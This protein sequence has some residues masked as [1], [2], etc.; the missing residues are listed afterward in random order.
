V[1]FTDEGGTIT[2]KTWVESDSTQDATT[3]VEPPNTCILRC[4]I[5]DTGI[6]IS[7][8]RQSLLFSSFEQGE[9]SMSRKYGGTGLGLAISKNIVSMMD[10]EIWI[11]SEEGVGSTFSFYV[12]VE[13]SERIESDGDSS[14]ESP[15]IDLML[16][17]FSSYRVLLAE[18]VEINR[19]IVAALLEPT[20]IGLVLAENGK[21]A[22]DIFCSDPEHYDIILMDMQMPE[23]DGL[24][25]TRIIRALDDPHAKSIPI[26][27]LTANVFK[28][29]IDRCL[30][31]GMNDHLGK[32]LD[33]VLI[34]EKLREYLP[35]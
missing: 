21:E 14:I 34:L 30:A 11:V 15:P 9:N 35:A 24:E 13:R 1:K 7:P 26:I 16:D 22:V 32:P 28:E 17:D 19:E 20:Q 27:A 12:K 4:D 5:I 6:G 10:G 31:A 23:M 8:E 25:A 18:D 3:N 29:D 2:L 33:F